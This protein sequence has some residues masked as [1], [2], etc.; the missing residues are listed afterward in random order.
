MAVKGLILDLDGTIVDSACLEAL[1]DRRRW[2]ECVARLNETTCFGDLLSVLRQV[3]DEGIRIGIVT[4]SVSF[5]AAAALKHHRIPYNGLIAYH[6][7]RPHK[8]HPAPV[9][10]CL[11]KLL[12]APEHAIGVGDTT[13]D[14]AAYL[15]AGIP[16]LG[17]GWNDKL[18][19]DAEWHQILSVPADL[20][21]YLREKGKA[22][23]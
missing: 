14:C 12:I 5:Y 19:R 1:R 2:T 18:V 23:A 16:T 10:A 21:D 3:S 17:A 8:P 13:A 20:L 22:S 11:R 9:L 7:A 6:D 4:S 15:A